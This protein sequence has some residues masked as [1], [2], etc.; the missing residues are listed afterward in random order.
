MFDATCLRRVLPKAY[1]SDITHGDVVAGFILHG[2]VHYTK[3]SA[4]AHCRVD[5]VV[6]EA[7]AR[8]VWPAGIRESFTGHRVGVDDDGYLVDIKNRSV[9]KTMK[10][11]S[12]KT[13][14]LQTVS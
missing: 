6:A 11:A 13:R 5:E 10:I 9:D 2:Y 12:R 4:E 1:P 8:G 7:R 14:Y 3:I